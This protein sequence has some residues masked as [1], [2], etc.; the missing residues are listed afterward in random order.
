LPLTVREARRLAG[1]LRRALADAQP[2]RP[3]TRAPQVPAGRPPAD[4]VA[5]VRGVTVAYGPVV[6]LHDVDLSVAPGDVVAVMG[7][8]GAGKSTLLSSLVGLSSPLAGRVRVGGHDPRSL[9]G[10]RLLH[11]VG[12]VPQQAGDLLYADSVADECRS[13]DRDAGVPPGRT[14]DLFARIAPG[15]DPAGHPRDLSEG[16]RLSL[17]LAVVLVAE[18]PLLLLDEP[19]RGLDYEAKARL[20]ELL[21]ALTGPRD[22]GPARACLLATHDV[23]LAA[24]VATRTV[25]VADGEIVTDGPTAEVLV[26]SPAF[27]PQVAKVLAPEPWL[28]VAQVAAALPVAG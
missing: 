27:A 21:R 9:Q 26:S 14:L 10:G 5:E 15:V 7:R 20:V 18:P 28:T 19:T 24:E 2:A 4:A 12:L 1:P 11:T 13:A 6:A 23:E 8:N 25:V 3:A 16:Q 17:A 22:D